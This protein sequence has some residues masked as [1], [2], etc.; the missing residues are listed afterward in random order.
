MGNVGWYLADNTNGMW[1][2]ASDPAFAEMTTAK[3]LI[4]NTAEREAEVK[5]IVIVCYPVGDSI[6]R[7]NPVPLPIYSQATLF[8]L[9][10]DC[11]ACYDEEISVYRSVT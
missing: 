8:S 5:R 3:N 2:A 4:A 10:I 6:I 1:G 11:D 9:R 7:R